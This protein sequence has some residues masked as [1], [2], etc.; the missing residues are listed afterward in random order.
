ME[1]WTLELDVMIID[2]DS[3]NKRELKHMNIL[4][5]F[6]HN[7]DYFSLINFY[8][9]A[10]PSQIEYVVNIGVFWADKSLYSQ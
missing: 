1:L 6:I 9:F 8:A 4:H 3:V 10:G 5:V 2:I 7:D